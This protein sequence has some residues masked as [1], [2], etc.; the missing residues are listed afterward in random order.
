MANCNC[1]CNSCTSCTGIGIVISL[2]LGVIAAF[3]RYSAVITIGTSFLWVTFGIAVL[4]LLLAL[5]L[6]SRARG[7]VR[8]C[9]CSHSTG[10][11]TGIGGT[12][13]TSLVLLAVSFAATST[14]GAIIS[15]LLVFSFFLII[16]TLICLIPCL[17][18][19]DSC[20]DD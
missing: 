3:L 4:V 13:V 20:S 18:G 7:S 11:L 12:I 1:N 14:V 8:E 19:C 6:S 15:G 2:V 17:A 9:M 16:S 10:L 5:Y